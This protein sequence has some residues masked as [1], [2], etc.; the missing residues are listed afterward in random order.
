MTT[1]ALLFAYNNEKINYVQMAAWTASNIRRHLNIPVCVVTD[2]RSIGNYTDDFDMIIYT[3][4]DRTNSR[5]FGD[6][7]NVTWHNTNR[8]DAYHLSPWDQT[9]VLDVDY[10]V[11][12]NQLKTLL[13]INLDFV[14]PNKAFDVVGLNDF[15]GLNYF[16][17][18]NMPMLW[19][20]VMI[21]R[22]SKTAQMIFDTM[23]M[24]RDNWDHYRALYH[25]SVASYRNDHA[26]TVAVNVVN[27]NNLSGPAM[28][29]SLASLTPDHKLMQ[30][31]QDS[32]RVDY[33]DPLG[34]PQWIKL[35]GQDFH[36]MGKQQLGAIVA[37]PL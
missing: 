28:P 20:T 29:W 15:T 19:A 31:D 22:R 37:N 24:V 2:T 12:S 4:N 11:A 35:S 16:G 33:I 3:Q 21:F 14:A 36:A 7:G 18:Y 17:L 9:L 34:K 13:K 5:Y 10:I 30:L 32:Y 27:G 26:L 23:Q 6:V 25:N 8:T 1:G